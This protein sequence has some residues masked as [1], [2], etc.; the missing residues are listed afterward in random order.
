M[1]TYFYFFTYNFDLRKNVKLFLCIQLKSGDFCSA[2]LILLLL[3]ILWI[4]K[5]NFAGGHHMKFRFMCD[6]WSYISW[7]FL[8]I[9][10]QKKLEYNWR[11]EIR[12]QVCLENGHLMGDSRGGNGSVSFDYPIRSNYNKMNLNRVG[13]FRSKK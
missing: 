1:Y 6:K 5:W 11:W 8:Q 3:N 13:E 4:L 10:F 7:I 2:T 9:K 12:D